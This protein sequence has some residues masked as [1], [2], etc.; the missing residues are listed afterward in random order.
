MLIDY[1][2]INPTQIY[3]MMS[4]SVIPRPIAWIVTED[5]GV[6]NIAPFSYFTPLSSNPATV[7]VSIGHKRD[8]S[9]KD[10]LAN[11]RNTKKATICFVDLAHMPKM[12]DS[13]H[14]QPKEISEAELYNIP[15]KLVQE[16]FPP[17]VDGAQSA[18]FCE[19]HSEIALEGKTI[20]LILEVKAQFV[21]D[22]LIDEELNFELDNIGRVGKQFASLKKI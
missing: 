1:E 10:T 11:V 4:Q 16:G 7:I 14:E 15:T 5:D 21:E 12:I 18:M 6:V 19:F 2:T 9:P 20:P 13:S 3:K 17:I 8:A 22:T